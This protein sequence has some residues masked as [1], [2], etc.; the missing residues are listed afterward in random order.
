ML[1][2]LMGKSNKMVNNP[3]RTQLFFRDDYTFAFRKLP[4]VESFMI[5]GKKDKPTKAWRHFFKLQFPFD[6]YRN[7][8]ADAVSIGFDRDIFYDPFNVL[9][10]KEK[11]AK[12]FDGTAA[13]RKPWVQEIAT[14]QVYKHQQQKP[15]GLLMDK[16]TVGLMIVLVL[17]GLAFF[18]DRVV[19]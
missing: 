17:M 10:T 4:I 14:A 1:D 7:I 19:R 9:D 6:G 16:V 3:K 2:W 15:K 12:G 18:L 8:P 11:P 5:E 13:L